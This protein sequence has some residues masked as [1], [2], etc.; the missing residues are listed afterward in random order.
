MELWE[1]I[2]KVFAAFVT[3]NLIKGLERQI[4]CRAG[5]SFVLKIGRSIW[6]SKLIMASLSA[7]KLLVPSICAIWWSL[8]LS[9][10]STLREMTW[11]HT[12]NGFASHSLMTTK[13]SDG[14]PSKAVITVLNTKNTVS[15]MSIANA[16]TH[17]ASSAR[18]NHIV[19]AH[20]M[21]QANGKPRILMK[22]KT[23]H[24]SWQILKHVRSANVLLRRIKGA[25]TWPVNYVLMNSAGCVWETGR[26]MAKRQAATTIATSMK[27][28]RSRE[29]KK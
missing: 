1:R 21:S 23:L 28:W 19:R 24:G 13:M 6:F 7:W 3:P 18:R 11:R 26:S 27:K 12:W 29:T 25:I 5:M 17:S 14:V 2:T 10:W 4:V 16:G 9:S 15:A 22:V 20:V 8:I